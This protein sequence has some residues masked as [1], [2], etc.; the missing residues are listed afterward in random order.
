ML[1]LTGGISKIFDKA[2]FGRATLGKASHYMNV[3]GIDGGRIAQCLI[4]ANAGFILASGQ[5]GKPVFIGSKV[6]TNRV[7]PQHGQA[8]GVE[9]GFHLGSVICIWPVTFNRF[10]SSRMRRMDGVHQGSV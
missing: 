5:G 9:C 8:G 1:L 10:K 7:Q 4:N 6:S 3:W 2:V